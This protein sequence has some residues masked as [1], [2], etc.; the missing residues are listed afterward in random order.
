MFFFSLSKYF[1]GDLIYGRIN[2]DPV[3]SL[4]DSFSLNI[5]KVFIC[6]GKDGYIPKYDPDNQEYGCVVDSP[7]LHDVFK[8][9]V[10]I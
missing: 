5:D 10:S 9:L 7:N 4:Q 8:I 6:S 2:I 1:S 3:Q